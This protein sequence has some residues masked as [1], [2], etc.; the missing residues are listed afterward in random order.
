MNRKEAITVT[1]LLCA[2]FVTGV[3]AEN[4]PTSP[5]K[6][7]TAQTTSVDIGLFNPQLFNQQVYVQMWNI[8]SQL[9]SPGVNFTSAF[10][11]APVNGFAH[12]TSVA[13]TMTYTSSF[14][15]PS[16]SIMAVN[17]MINGQSSGSLT[18]QPE[19][20]PATTSGFL[21]IQGLRP[22]TN[23]INMGLAINDVLTLYQA[24]LTIE[25]TFSA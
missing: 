12:V 19:N 4:S 20:S 2:T 22:G 8:P 1:A 3:F 13:L 16:T 24:H 7:I 23:T 14:Y 10:A 11:F 17:L 15:L 21:G 6:T 9:S 18:L 25:Y 5:T